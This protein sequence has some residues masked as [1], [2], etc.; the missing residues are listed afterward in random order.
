MSRVQH[1]TLLHACAAK[2]VEQVQ[3]SLLACAAKGV[4]QVQHLT[5]IA[6]LCSDKCAWMLLRGGSQTLFMYSWL[7]LLAWTL[8]YYV[9]DCAALKIYYCCYNLSSMHCDC[10]WGKLRSNPPWKFCSDI[11]LYTLYMHGQIL[12]NIPS[13]VHVGA[14]VCVHVPLTAS[15]LLPSPAKLNPLTLK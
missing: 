10:N 14:S 3:H 12:V 9:Y 8:G 2:G 7:L 11:I 15:L 5:F 13:D 6:C 4:E 1:L